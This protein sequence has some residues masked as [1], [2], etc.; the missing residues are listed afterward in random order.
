M[1]ISD[2]PRASEPKASINRC[3]LIRLPFISIPPFELFDERDELCSARLGLRGFSRLAACIRFLGAGGLDVD[4]ARQ[5]SQL[6]VCLLLFLESLPQ[7]QHGLVFSENL[8]VSADT[9]VTGD[10]VVLHPLSGG[11]KPGIQFLGRGIFRD[12]F[13]AFFDEAL[14]ACI[15]C[16]SGFLREL[17]KSFRG[18]LRVL[19]SAPSALQNPRASPRKLR[20]WP[21]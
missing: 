19:S 7:E 9:A 14:H 21:S 11:D 17:S 16:H 13:A 6:L 8:C 1:A 10:S 2:A 12:Q 3:D 15:S 18:V 5:L 4:L 20:L